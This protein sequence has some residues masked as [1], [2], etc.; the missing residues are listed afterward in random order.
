M[1]LL[2]VSK[3][4]FDERGS[5]WASRARPGVVSYRLTIRLAVLT[6]AFPAVLNLAV[7]VDHAI[8]QR[9]LD[10]GDVAEHLR[11]RSLPASRMIV[12]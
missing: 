6:E 3:L 5:T 9:V 8:L 7:N 11:L 1:S 2:T 10:L 4:T 12:R